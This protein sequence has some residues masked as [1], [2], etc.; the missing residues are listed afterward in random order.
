[1]KCMHMYPML[2]HYKC[3]SVGINKLQFRD[4]VLISARCLLKCSMAVSRGNTGIPFCE[5]MQFNGQVSAR[6]AT[7]GMENLAWK[8]KCGALDFT[9]NGQKLQRLDLQ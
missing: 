8:V 9:P 3:L 7:R 1:M 2:L 4:I 6:S 5:F